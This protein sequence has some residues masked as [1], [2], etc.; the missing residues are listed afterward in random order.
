M[1]AHSLFVEGTRATIL[2]GFPWECAFRLIKTT[3]RADAAIVAEYTFARLNM[4]SPEIRIRESSVR[5]Y[6]P[7]RCQANCSRQPRE[8]QLNPINWTSAGNRCEAY[9]TCVSEP[10]SPGN[11]A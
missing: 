8:R 3:R 9:S 6:A 5:G 10:R 2:A 4:M 7:R 11:R 1:P